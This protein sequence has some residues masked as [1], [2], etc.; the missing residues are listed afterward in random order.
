MYISRSE[1][2]NKLL[3]IVLISGL[4]VLAAILGQRA[5]SGGNCVSCAGKG[6]CAG[7]SDCSK[8]LQEGK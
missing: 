6:I 4:A 2:L 5:V 7:E 8:Y 3:R 1:F